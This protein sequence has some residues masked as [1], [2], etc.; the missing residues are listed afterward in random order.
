MAGSNSILLKHFLFGAGRFAKQVAKVFFN[1]II[2][3][4]RA[5]QIRTGSRNVNGF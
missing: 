5:G 3:N 4:G 1:F 2:R